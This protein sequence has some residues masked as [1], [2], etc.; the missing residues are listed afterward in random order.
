MKHHR[1]APYSKFFHYLVM[2]LV[3]GFIFSASAQAVTHHHKK[4]TSTQHAQKAP[5]G[6][7]KLTSQPG[8][9]LENTARL[10]N[11]SDMNFA[12]QRNEQPLLLIGSLNL[13]STKKP[14]T[15][16][17]TQIQ[18]ASL[19]G[20]GG[21]STTGYIKRNNQWVKVLD[22]VTGDITVEKATHKGMH[23]LSVSASDVW[24]WNGKTYIETQKGPNLK[25]LKQ[26]IEKHQKSNNS[27]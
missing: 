27:L 12:I 17:F 23:D 14:K 13:S 1:Y 19:C 11:Q 7:V 16:L 15:I 4:K 10:L 26:S 25:G 24:R 9:A 8:T 5:L 6:K 21:C 2:F 3:S 22:A 18:T 20:S